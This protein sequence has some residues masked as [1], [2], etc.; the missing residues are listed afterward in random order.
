MKESWF[1][2]S[3]PATLGPVSVALEVLRQ[4]NLSAVT[5]TNAACASLFYG[6]SPNREGSSLPPISWS[7]REV[8]LN[9]LG[10]QQIYVILLL[11]KGGQGFQIPVLLCCLV[12][13]SLWGK[14]SEESLGRSWHCGLYKEQRFV[15]FGSEQF[16]D[17]L[18]FSG[19][20]KSRSRT[21]SL[22]ALQERSCI[23]S[24]LRAKYPHASSWII[25]FK[26]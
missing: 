23:L 2:L 17:Y 26:L 6:H 22:K 24:G 5:V 3:C 11:W 7:C 8:Q 19:K 1:S 25:S 18:I 13:N 4:A 15:S 9:R 10:C 12:V 14:G 21:K 16:L 20:M